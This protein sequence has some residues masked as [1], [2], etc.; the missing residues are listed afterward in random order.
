MIVSGRQQR[1]S[2]THICES[3]LP[4]MGASQVVLVVK[5]LP[6]SAG[7]MR[8]A[9]PIPGLGRS[10]GG[11]HGNPLHYS[12]LENPLDRGA[13]W[14]IAYRAA[15]S[16]T[17]LKRLSMHEYPINMSEQMYTMKLKNPY[18]KLVTFFCLNK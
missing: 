18:E 15:K 2:T 11:E 3:I 12:C 6:A 10:H 4:Q 7:D 17:R 13:W 9:G 5:N 1:D 14:A 16:W 8:D